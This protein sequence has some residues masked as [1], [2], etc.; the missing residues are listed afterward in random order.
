MKYAYSRKSVDR[1][2]TQSLTFFLNLW[3]LIVVD[4]DYAESSGWFLSGGNADA[5]QAVYKVPDGS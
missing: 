4:C 2:S 3:R 1:I 5:S